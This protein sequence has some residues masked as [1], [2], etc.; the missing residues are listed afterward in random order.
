MEEEEEF[1]I[2]CANEENILPTGSFASLLINIS[3]E[4]PAESEGI[5][6]LSDAIFAPFDAPHHQRISVQSVQMDENAT[7]Q[8]NKVAPKR[9]R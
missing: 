1:Q 3:V 9:G 8:S 4:S 2:L 5:H 7:K 6:L